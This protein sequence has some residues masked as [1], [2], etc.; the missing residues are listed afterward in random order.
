MKIVKVVCGVIW[1]DDKVFIAKRK[2]EKSL[3]GFWEFPGGKIE[4]NESPELALERELKEELGMTV[5]VGKYIGQNIHDYDN[6]SIELM[7]YRCE[8]ITASFILTDHDEFCFTKP[9]QLI[10]YKIAPADLL[11]LPIISQL[12]N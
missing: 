6:F 2:P 3:G 4:E 11:L 9:N 1:Q 12:E 5:K 10:K 7:A 8:F